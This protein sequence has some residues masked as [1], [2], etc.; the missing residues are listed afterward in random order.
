MILTFYGM[1]GTEIPAGT[2]VALD[3]KGNFTLATQHSG[4]VMGT[5]GNTNFG[6]VQILVIPQG[7]SRRSL[8][9]IIQDDD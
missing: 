1:P 3:A 6:S 8:W 7:P 5:V 9:E 4:I 2:L